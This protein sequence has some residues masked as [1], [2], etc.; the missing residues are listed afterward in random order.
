MER[1]EEDNNTSDKPTRY[2]NAHP[3]EKIA[4]FIAAV[5]DYMKAN[6]QKAPPEEPPHAEE[7]LLSSCP[8]ALKALEDLT[9][10]ARL[11]NLFGIS[12]V[13]G[14]SST[15]PARGNMSHAALPDKEQENQVGTNAYTGADSHPVTAPLVVERCRAAARKGR[16]VLKIDFGE[17]LIFCDARHPV[18]DPL[19]EIVYWDTREFQEEPQLFE[20]II[21]KAVGWDAQFIYT[22]G[23]DRP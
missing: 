14:C 21:K 10:P 17:C 13:C 12:K 22:I 20:G 19:H 23:N 2:A 6:Y 3:T 5:E 8:D 9:H 15:P 11:S 4:S 1:P 18:D 16:L 7:L